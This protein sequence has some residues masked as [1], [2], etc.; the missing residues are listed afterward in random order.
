MCSYSFFLTA[1]VCKDAA[2]A[3]KEPVLKTK[4]KFKTGGSKSRRELEENKESKASGSAY[5]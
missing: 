5:R 3:R 2:V 4:V 1:K